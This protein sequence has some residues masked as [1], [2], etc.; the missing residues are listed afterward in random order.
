MR[1]LVFSLVVSVSVSTIAS[2][3]EGNWAVAPYL[4]QS[5][6]FGDVD[7]DHPTKAVSP[8]AGFQLQYGIVDHLDTYVDLGY[9]SANGGNEYFYNESQ[10]LMTSVGVQYDVLRA[11]SPDSKVG[12]DLDFSLGWNFIQANSYN[13]NTDQP[14]NRIPAQGA[15]SNAPT[16]RG[17]ALISYPV[18]NQV[19]VFAGYKMYMQYDN[20]WADGINSGESNDFIGQIS[21]GVRFAIDGRVP[22]AK[23]TQGDY[24]DLVAAKRQAEQDRDAA[25]EE[26]ESAR[27]RYDT[28]IEDMYNVLSVMNNNIDSLNEKITVLR[29]NPNGASNEYQVQSRNGQAGTPDA[30]NAMWRI[31]IGSF[32]TSSLAREFADRHVV[33]GGN[34]EVVFIQDL[35]TYRVVYDSYPSLTA[36]KTD[37]TRVKH[38]ISNAWII[39]F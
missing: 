5:S 2:A 1:K 25:R 8:G 17:G 24:D 32:P 15:Y 38:T 16:I 10:F 6:V 14:I 27:N 18:S 13:P 30:G 35:N 39:K 3:Q 28:Q 21:V 37:L 36:A 20:D 19:D 34:Y 7:F 11:F 33:E 23:V 4:T 9:H 31:V 26:L 12:I 22:M 29:S